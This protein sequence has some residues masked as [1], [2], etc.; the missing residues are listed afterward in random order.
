MRK[1]EK[2]KTHE[3]NNMATLRSVQKWEGEEE[4][5]RALELRFFCMLW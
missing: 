4:V 5:L 2:V 3:V 1:K